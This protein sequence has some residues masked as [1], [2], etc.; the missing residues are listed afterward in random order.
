MAE[1]RVIQLACTKSSDPCTLAFNGKGRFPSYKC[2]KSMS[3]YGV[4]SS[5]YDSGTGWWKYTYDSTKGQTKSFCEAFNYCCK[6][7]NSDVP[8]GDSSTSACM[9]AQNYGSGYCN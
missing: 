3:D 1:K 4:S 2:G 6:H 9:I 5:K 8:S 7:G